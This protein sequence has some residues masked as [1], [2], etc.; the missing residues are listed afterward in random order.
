MG[1][2]KD[3]RITGDDADEF[4]ID[5]GKEFNVDVSQ[6]PIG[7]YF[8]GEK[9]FYGLLWGKERKA[10]KTIKVDHLVK[11]IIAGRLDEDVINS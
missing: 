11:A 3:L 1:L 2:E 9:P 10:V 6:F 5:F 4:L 7:E 8:E